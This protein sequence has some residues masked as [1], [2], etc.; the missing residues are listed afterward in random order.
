MSTMF[1][2]NA[3]LQFTTLTQNHIQ[4]TREASLALAVVVTTTKL[5]V[6]LSMRNVSTVIRKGISQLC[7]FRR[8]ETRSNQGDHLKINNTN[9]LSENRIKYQGGLRRNLLIRWRRL[10][11]RSNLRNTRYIFV[12]Q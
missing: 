5:T 2:T 3:Y 8:G 1:I 6:P 4:N 11:N 10:Q 12:T 7:V 9:T